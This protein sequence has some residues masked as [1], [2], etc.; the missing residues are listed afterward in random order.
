MRKTPFLIT[1]LS[2]LPALSAWG[3]QHPNIVFILADDMGY[4]DVSCLG[5]DSSLLH[6]PNIDRLAAEGVA[7]TDAHSGSAVSTPTRYGILTGRYSWRSTLKQGVL[8]G[9]SPALIAEGQETVASMLKE[10]GYATACIG[11]WHLGWDWANIAAGKDSVDFSRPIANGPTTR[12]FD[13]FY[14]FIAGG[15]HYFYEP[16]RDDKPG[17]VRNLQLNGVQQKF[18]GYLTDVLADG[19]INFLRQNDKP[20]MMYLAFNAVHTSLQATEADLARFPNHPRRLLAAMTW[21][22]DRAIGKVVHYLE[23][24]G[25]MD[26]TLIFF[27]SDNG[28]AHDNQSCTYPLK[29]FK[30]NKYEGGIRVPFFVVWKNHLKEGIRFDGLTSSLDIFAT[31]ASAAGIQID[32]LSQPL[33]GVNLLPYFTQERVGDPHEKLFW[34]KDQMAAVRI[35]DYK[36]IRVKGVGEVGAKKLIGKYGTARE[37]YSHLDELTPKQKSAFEEARGHIAMSHDLV[38]IRT[39]VP[40][41]IDTCAMSLDA[42]FSSKAAEIS[43]SRGPSTGWAR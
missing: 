18:D 11:K 37:I 31:A 29:G 25:L 16:D 33:D 6:T 39:D 27:L 35:G 9:Y 28:G 22:V 23:T 36:L 32:T 34:R 10:E 13:Y 20:F 5:A 12:G 21:A 2:L 41:D 4:G 38:T 30:G 17:S 14:G 26:N 7:F 40:V 15:R 3:Q 42:G 43:R 24:S 1:G 8:N 19:A